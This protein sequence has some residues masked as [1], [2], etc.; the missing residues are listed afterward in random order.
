MVRAF[1]SID[2]DDIEIKTN[3]EKIQI[4]LLQTGAALKVVK[5]DLLHLTLA[6]LGE[7]SEEEIIS[8]KEI[9]DSLSFTKFELTVKN[10]NV[11]PSE[12]YIRVVYCLIDGDIPVLMK[13]QNELKTKLKKAGFRVEKR[14]FKAHLTIARVKSPKNKQELLDKISE[15]ES[16]YCGKQVISSIKLKK[17]VLK[18]EGPEY[19]TLH[20]VSLEN[21]II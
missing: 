8:L 13:I 11:L 14:P 1:I 7:V 16:I 15:Y 9:L 2:F 12:N 20:K 6:F 18:K 17:S 4:S 10:P 19:T 21:D 5:I 3:I